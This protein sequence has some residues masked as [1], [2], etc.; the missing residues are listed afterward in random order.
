MQLGEKPTGRGQAS[1]D[2]R[3]VE[4]LESGPAGLG[5]SLNLAMHLEQDPQQ[6]GSV[7]DRVITPTRGT[8]AAATAGTSFYGELNDAARR[9]GSRSWRTVHSQAGFSI[10]PIV[11]YHAKV[12]LVRV[13]LLDSGLP[14]ERL[15]TQLPRCE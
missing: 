10:K 2:G 12:M 3:V 15:H 13:R 7:R 4:E 5:P 1:Y 8:L 6:V 14:V 11:K 9:S